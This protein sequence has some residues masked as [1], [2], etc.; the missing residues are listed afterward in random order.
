MHRLV[1]AATR[2]VPVLLAITLSGC[3]VSGGGSSL[4]SS[5]PP[6]LADRAWNSPIREN[7]Q[8]EYRV[9]YDM[10]DG[11][12]D[13]A[14]IEPYGYVFRPDVN[15]VAWEPYTNGY[16][17]PSD[18]WG[19]VWVSADPFGWATDHYGRWMNDRFQGWVWVPGVQWA[20]AWVQWVGDADYIGWAPLGAVTSG[21]NTPGYHFVPVGALTST[22]LSAQVVKPPVIQQ[23][24][25][26]L[27]PIDNTLERDGVKFEAGPR[28]EWFERRV[29][30]VTRARVEDVVPPGTLT[31]QG[32]GDVGRR[33]APAPRDGAARDSVRAEHEARLAAQRAAVRA[34]DEARE[35]AKSGAPAP[36]NVTVVRPFGPAPGGRN[37]PPAERRA[38]ARRGAPADSTR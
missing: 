5:A 27:K 11:L 22:D 36:A 29:G 28:L 2:S 6:P 12:G 14:L 17:V 35:R 38:P 15:F 13:W 1:R 25:A 37:A 16:W 34:A 32:R 23:R 20:P 26:D 19:W 30:P 4:S 31:R 9:F 10:L 18:T 7:M 21:F 8:P 3:A 24:L 33:E